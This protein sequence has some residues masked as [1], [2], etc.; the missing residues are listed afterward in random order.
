MSDIQEWKPSIN[1]WIMII[2]V[3][4]AAFICIL[5]T[6]IG[7]VALSHMAGAFS[8]SRDESMWILTSYLVAAGIVMPAVD[9]LSKIFGRK[10]YFVLSILLFTIS[11]F[12]GYIDAFRIFGIFGIFCNT[13]FVDD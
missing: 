7:N 3:I 2:P 9:W 11:T 5:D 4:L 13:T 1:P 6:T 10:N 12:L 8:A